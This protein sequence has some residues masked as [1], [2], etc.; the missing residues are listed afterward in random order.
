MVAI[1]SPI[2]IVGNPRSGTTLLRLMLTS[3]H[4]IVIPPESGFAIWYYDKYKNWKELIKQNDYV[5]TNFTKDL[6][7]AKKF[8]NWRLDSNEVYNY[9]KHIKPETYTMLIAHIYIFYA[10]KIKPHIIYW[11]D[12]NNFY[13]NHILTLKKIFPDAFF[14]HIIRDGRNVACSYKKIMKKKFK[15]KYAPQLPSDITDIALEWKKNINTIRNSFIKINYNNVLEIKFED[16]INEPE[17]QLT[18][19]CQL[20]GINFD[21]NMLQYHKID[22]SHGLEPKE[23]LEWKAKNQKPLL[24]GEISR[25]KNELSN[26]EAE[27]FRDIAKDELEAYDYI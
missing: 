4:Q 2:F 20:I 1:T 16:L 19:I 15:S 21:E 14:I 26:I 18:R 9:L 8:E 5:L 23:F 13:L 22:E 27:K 10:Q 6:F 17:H 7:K 3:H 11:G 12:K 24:K 25:F